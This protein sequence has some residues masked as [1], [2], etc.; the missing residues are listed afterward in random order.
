MSV[1][2]TAT[3]LKCEMLVDP[4]E[5]DYRATI[6]EIVGGFPVVSNAKNFL[7][8]DTMSKPDLRCITE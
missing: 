1:V 3:A 5:C 8:S 6:R 2:K 7:K 4:R